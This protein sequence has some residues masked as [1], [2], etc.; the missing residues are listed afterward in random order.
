MDVLEEGEQNNIEGQGGKDDGRGLPAPEEGPGGQQTRLKWPRNELSLGLSGSCAYVKT[1]TQKHLE[2]LLR[3]VRAR[4][5][6]PLCL[7]EEK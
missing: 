2:T 7:P 5:A 4:G 3:Q 1:G 6:E